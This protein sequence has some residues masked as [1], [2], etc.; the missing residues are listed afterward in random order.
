MTFGVVKTDEPL[1]GELIAIA[2]EATGH[3]CLVFEDVDQAARILDALY[4]DALVLDLHLADRSGLDWLEN[5]V[6]TRP[7][8][9]ART[10]LLTRTATTSDEAARIAALGAEVAPRPA[11]VTEV[12]Y[13]VL[14][15]LRRVGAQ[16]ADRSGPRRVYEMRVYSKQFES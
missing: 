5:V 7:D 10:L 2:F 14:E 13:V 4:L 1:L 3:D 15:R 8:L 16:R 11:S 9:P 6:A 12:Q